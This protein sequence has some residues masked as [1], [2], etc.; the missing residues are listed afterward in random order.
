MEPMECSPKNYIT[1]VDNN[2][3]SS[4]YHHHYTTQIYCSSQY[5]KNGFY[6]DEAYY[7][8]T[9]TTPTNTNQVVRVIK[10]RTTANKKE[11]RRTQ[12]INSAYSCLRDRIPNVPSD[13]KLSKIKTLRLATSYI[14]YLINVLEGEQEPSGF[15]A[16]LVPSSRKIN[17]E[18]RA[19][20]K[21][22]LQVSVLER[23][24]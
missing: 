17:A 24:E 20:I 11:R 12:S 15:R 1:N 21:N 4:P 14:S 7:G 2:N 19:I 22:E 13:T 8:A 23:E 10:R 18:R 9:T 6:C 5:E 3:Q 16:E